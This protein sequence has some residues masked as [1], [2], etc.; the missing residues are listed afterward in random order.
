[1]TTVTPRSRRSVWPIVLLCTAAAVMLGTS[2]EATVPMLVLCPLLLVYGATGLPRMPRPRTFFAAVEAVPFAL[3]VRYGGDSVSRLN[4]EVPVG[5]LAVVGFYMLTVGTHHVLADRNGGSRDYALSCAVMAVGIAGAFRDSVVYLPLLGVFAV[6]LLWH[7]RKEL[8]ER[9]PR[10]RGA[11]GGWGAGW[12]VGAVVLLVCITL[13]MD[14]G[15]VRQVPRLSTMML[16]AMGP[17][18]MRSEI[19]FDRVTN[20]TNLRR[21]WSDDQRGSEVM[22][23][24]FAKN[25]SHYLRGAVYGHYDGGV[26]EVMREHR[27]L[28]PSGTELGRNVF[29]ITTKDSRRIIGVIYPASELASDFFLPLG[30][31]EVASYTSRVYFGEARTM[32]PIGDG[33][34]GGYVMF[35]PVAAMPPPMQ[36]DL[37]V[38]AE[39]RGPLES[40]LRG[41]VPKGTAPAAT[42]DAIAEYFRKNFHYEL[43]VQRRTSMDP[44]LEFLLKLKRGHCE[45]F[46]SAGCLLLREA[47]VAARYSTGF[48]VTE[49]GPASDLWVARRRDAHAWVEA[50]LP[51]RGWQVVDM[52]PGTDRPAVHRAETAGQQWV[53]WARSQWRRVRALAMFGGL[54][55]MVTG[56]M[57]FITGLPQRVPAWGWVVL[58][59]G[60]VVWVVRKELLMALRRRRGPV[61]PDVR[62][63]RVKLA[64]AEAMLRRHGLVRR[65]SMTVAS[66]YA[67]AQRSEVPEPIRARAMRLLEEYLRVRFRRREPEGPDGR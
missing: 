16:R 59:A 54:R 30:V 35:E 22:L 42:A 43:G 39:L 10:A 38:P 51:G 20:L 18:S 58:V 67:M 3:W 2:A 41:I 44:V 24:I 53:M 40:V 64:D 8:V 63:L 56:A 19:G 60:G 32:R 7:L 33:A 34:M 37:E 49:Q 57:D 4:A 1:M 23:D 9:T 55:A 26:W 14:R 45:Y 21:F 36:G 28:Q 15:V 29:N 61:D 48:L 25:P 5:F 31:H 13:A 52:T 65:P 50:Y 6:L 11:G 62:A 17:G 27:V 12:Y 47:G 46:A 66:F